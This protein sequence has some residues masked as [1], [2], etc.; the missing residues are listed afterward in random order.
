MMANSTEKVPPDE[1]R[2]G[3]AFLGE[4]RKSQHS[5]GRERNRAAAGELGERAGRGARLTSAGLSLSRRSPFKKIPAVAGKE[6]GLHGLYNRVT[7]LGGFAKEILKDFSES[8][9]PNIKTEFQQVLSN[10]KEMTQFLEE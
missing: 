3:L 1:R 7:T 9:F 2:K 8:D 6:P 5:R 10:R 4:L